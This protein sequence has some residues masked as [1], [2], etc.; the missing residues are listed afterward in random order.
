MFPL[1][2]AL[3]SHWT[4]AAASAAASRFS[5]WVRTIINKYDFVDVSIAFH[6]TDCRRFDCHRFGRDLGKSV[7][8]R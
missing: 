4:A 5:K 8:I 3:I 6:C 7:E 2:R 1:Q